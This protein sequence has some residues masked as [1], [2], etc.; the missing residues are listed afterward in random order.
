M[1]LTREK[2]Q[3]IIKEVS[4]LLENSKMTVI[5]AYKGTPVKEMQELRRKGTE[6]ATTM[7]VVKNRLVIKAIEKTDHLKDIP[8]ES[9]NGMLLYAFNPEDEV[10]PAQVLAEFAKDQPTIEFVGAISGEGKLLSAEEVTEL[11]KLPSKDEIIAQ[12]MATLASP[13]ND[14]LSGLSGNLHGI[15]DG[16]E[17]KAST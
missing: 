11:S 13:L 15:L 8:T 7:K 10:A 12:V 6:N 1:A 14:T 17:A 4:N 2:K 3:Q 5:A 16:I 9:L